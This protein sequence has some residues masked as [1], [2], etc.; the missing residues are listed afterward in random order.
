[1]GPVQWDDWYAKWAAADI[2]QVTPAF[3]CLMDRDDITGPLGEI[4][5]PALIVHGSADAAIPLAKAQELRDGLAGPARLA[6]IEG[7][8]HASNMS[9]PAEVSAEML[10]FLREFDG[11]EQP[12]RTSNDTSPPSVA[13]DTHRTRSRQPFWPTRTP[14]HAAGRLTIGTA[15]PPAHTKVVFREPYDRYRRR[16]LSRDF[17]LNTKTRARSAREP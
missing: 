15:P 5:C 11:P 8:T 9:H 10:T 3:R 2:E 12:R 6:V 4:N 1:L 16:Q 7:G 14:E 17:E 13:P